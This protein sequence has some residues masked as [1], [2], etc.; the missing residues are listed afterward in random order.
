[1]PEDSRYQRFV[2]ASPDW[3]WE[4]SGDGV[5]TYSNPRVL[6][7]LG[8][9]PQEV[10]GKTAFDF[11]PEAEAGRISQVFAEIVSQRRAFS[12]L[13]NINL[14][15]QGRQ[16]I[17]ETSGQPVLDKNGNLLGYQGIDR[18]ITHLHDRD[19]LL[20][21]V[22]D[23]IPDV[24][25][26]KD[27]AGNF[28]LCNQ[29]VATLYDSTPE[30]M[31]GKRDRDFGVPEE[32]DRQ[33]LENVQQIMKQGKAEI[34]YEDS[35][36]S[37]TGK[38][39]HFRSIKTPIKD[40]QGNDQII[41][42]AQDVTQLVTAKKQIEESEQRLQNVL[43]VINEGLW[44]WHIPTGQLKHNWKW[45]RLLG[46]QSTSLNNTLKDFKK[47]LYREDIP[48]VMQRLDALLSG[49]KDIYE[50]EH[51]MLRAD[52]TV[53]WVL[54]RGKISERDVDGKPLR[55][56]GSINDITE[57]KQA[58][59]ALQQ[60]QAMLEEQ[61]EARTRELRF[62]KEMAEQANESKSRFLSN[63]SH[64]LRTP[65]HAIMSFCGLGLK[66]ART[67]KIRNYLS[68][69][70]L[71]GERLTKLLDD[72]LDLSKLESGNL[73]LHYADTD[74]TDLTHHCLSELDSLFTEK[75]LDVSFQAVSSLNALVD[76]KHIHQVITNLLSNA[77]KFS[78]PQS[79]LLIELAETEM[80]SR[81]AIQFSLQ[82]QGIGVPE[83]ELED[84]FDSFVQS[85]KTRSSR[86]GTGLGLP[87]SREIIV[88]HG[89]R[90]WA[91]SPPPGQSIGSLFS[92]V[93]PQ[94]AAD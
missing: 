46:L 39:R 70:H 60:H 67:E 22:I 91:E 65:M 66:H 81:P 77:I 8:Y 71:S 21:A 29:T 35:I 59:V 52:G 55:V 89:G 27:Q 38:T 40:P 79:L 43:E 51:R 26:L 78:P 25:V 86:G 34:V 4:V 62:A 2:E 76:A 74:L 10:L 61:V 3:L 84:I 90:I 33:M 69:I 17:L 87:I 5:Y 49:Q 73:T 20:R 72:L 56:I 48:Q 82:D 30:D 45:F 15:K 18:D 42:M 83:N 32:M 28:V 63:M 47:R 41:V 50:S 53:I 24:F 16:V 9:T 7:I 80:N 6:D 93:I 37:K 12:G 58:T 64:E 14:H 85:S 19:N 44:E 75:G 1:M 57:R 13:V 23:Q 92:F 88:L 54:D 68:K 11:M 31:V 36:D 94:L